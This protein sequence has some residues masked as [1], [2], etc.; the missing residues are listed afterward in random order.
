MIQKIQL[1][2]ELEGAISS[3]THLDEIVT[4]ITK[5]RFLTF[6]KWRHGD[7]ATA[8]VTGGLSNKQLKNN[9]G[10]KIETFHFI[11]IL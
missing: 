3:H 10:H 4:T 9:M 2:W 11:F 6:G 5:S 7:M 1:L 8:A